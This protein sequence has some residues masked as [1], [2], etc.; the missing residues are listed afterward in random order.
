MEAITKKILRRYSLTLCMIVLIISLI[1]GIVHNI[2]GLS[3]SNITKPL[4]LDIVY[5][6]GETII[7]FDE[8]DSGVLVY[9]E[10][11]LI[12]GGNLFLRGDS[13]V[14]EFIYS[15]TNSDVICIENLRG[16]L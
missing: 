10:F 12:G 9:E 13:L 7:T 11:S 4:T 1:L 6:D 5:N 16:P 3:D 8:K 2:K 15:K 14:I